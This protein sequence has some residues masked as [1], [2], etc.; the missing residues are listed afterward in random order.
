MFMMQR[1]AGQPAGQS[2]SRP[3][4]HKILEHGNTLSPRPYGVQNPHPHNP[5]SLLT[6]FNIIKDPSGLGRIPPK[7]KP[8][9]YENMADPPKRMRI[10]RGSPADPLR[11]PRG[12]P[13]QKQPSCRT[14][15]DFVGVV[16]ESVTFA[17]VL[18]SS[19]AIPV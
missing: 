5:C 11:I 9:A 17:E 15:N 8:N 7:R 19:C 3:R 4:P 6:L 1:L 18:L 13:I 10:P 2:T 16:T 12:S 14:R